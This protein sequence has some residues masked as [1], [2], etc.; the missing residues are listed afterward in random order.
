M[1][2]RNGN[3]NTLQRLALF[4]SLVLAAPAFAAEGFFDGFDHYDR[5]RWSRSDGWSNGD[6]MNCT[7][8]RDAAQ[9]RDGAMQLRILPGDP[10]RCGEIQSTN[11]YGHGTYEVRMRTAAGS[12]LNAAFFT[13]I[14]PVHGRTH[15]EIDVE[16]LLRDTAAVS[17]NTYV[18]GAPLNGTEVPLDPPSDSGFRTY[19]FTWTPDAITWFVDGQEVHRTTPGTPL[20]EAPQKI[21]ASLWSSGTFTDWMGPFDPASLPS[22]L[23]IDWIAFTPLGEP[24]AFPASIL[25]GGNPQ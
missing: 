19:A 2:R 18:D 8:F 15:G 25:C 21:Y 17:F 24:C 9:V 3:V 11:E 14:G 20:P 1:L 4:L 13:Y 5:G 7:W 12:G 16:I 6:W 22:T 10:V 23:D